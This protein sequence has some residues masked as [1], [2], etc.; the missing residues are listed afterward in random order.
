MR[1]QQGISSSNAGVRGGDVS[2]RWTAEAG[3]AQGAMGQTAGVDSAWAPN[4]RSGGI[5][6]QGV[7]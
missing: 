4:P 3:A 7:T 1:Q 6:P 5:L 2:T